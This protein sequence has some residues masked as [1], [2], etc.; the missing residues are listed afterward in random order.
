[1]AVFTIAAGQTLR[2][3]KLQTSVPLAE[4]KFFVGLDGSIEWRVT[5][6]Q[7]PPYTI[8]Y[9]IISTGSVLALPFGQPIYPNYPGLP[10]YAVGNLTLD[11]NFF[12]PSGGPGPVGTLTGLVWHDVRLLEYSYLDN[13]TLVWLYDL[14]F[15]DSL[16]FGGDDTVTLGAGDD[17][18][19]DFGGA[20]NASLGDGNDIA[21]LY[22]ASQGVT[23]VKVVNAGAGNDQ[24]YYQSGTGTIDGGAGDDAIGGAGN[25]DGNWLLIGGTGNDTISAS[26]YSRIED[27]RGSGNDVYSGNYDLSINDVIL[28]YAKGNAGIVVDLAMGTA[29][30]GTHGM[31]QIFGIRSVEGTRG[32]DVMTGGGVGVR[33]W[34]FQGNDTLHGSDVGDLLN[35]GTQEDQLFGY[36]GD[37]TVLGGSGNDTIVGGAGRDLLNGGLGQDVFVFAAASDSTVAG[38]G[39]DRITGFSAVDDVLDLSGIDANIVTATNDMFSFIGTAAFTA[40][41]QVRYEHIGGFTVVTTNSAAGLAPEMRI[42][43]AGIHVLTVDNFSL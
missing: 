8:I 34:G 29:G 9:Q 40:R 23:D 7:S 22:E 19:N 14:S 38:A 27:A 4:A 15:A 18:F 20:L 42:D 25:N 6:D 3:D 30:G 13:G 36:A 24:V 43:I 26:A 31:D 37:D 35:G 21:Y 28:S 32:N 11:M 2:M 12:D 39:R 10:G 16:V 1:M 5:D 17:Y 41:G 33:F